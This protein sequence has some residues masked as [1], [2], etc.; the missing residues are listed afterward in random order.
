[1]AYIQDA[2]LPMILSFASDGTYEDAMRSEDDIEQFI[3]GLTRQM[4]EAANMD[5]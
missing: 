5:W 2:C 4:D 3:Y 1:V